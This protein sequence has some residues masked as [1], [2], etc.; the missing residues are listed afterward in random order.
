KPANILL[1]RSGTIR[2]LDLGLARFYEDNKDLLT[3]K[4]DDNNV[5]GT[6]DYVSPEQARDSHDVDIR[7]DI[8]S[9]G[10]TFYFLLTGQTL[11]PEGKVAQ[12]L[13]WHQTRQPRPVR[14]LRPEVP[15]EIDAIIGKMLAKNRAERYQT[16]GE[17]LAALEPWVQKP[18]APPSEEE[19]PQPCP[20]ARA[21]S[22]EVAAR[23]PTPLAIHRS[24]PTPSPETRRRGGPD[25]GTRSRGRPGVTPVVVSPPSGHSGGADLAT[26]R[27]LTGD[28][29]TERTPPG[30]RP[31]PQGTGVRSQE[32]AGKLSSLAPDP[33]LL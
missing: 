11:F 29:P 27:V 5:L 28:S 12:K 7:T 18:I 26:P 20:V 1:D 33:C 10:A 13:I 16:P 9:L 31:R 22:A 32:S 17:V 2:I 23:T 25:E 8:Y 4:Y 15:E 3:L 6:A 30:S 24:R 21:S 19:I 14:A